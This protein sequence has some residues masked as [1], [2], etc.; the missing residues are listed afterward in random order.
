MDCRGG[1]LL[2]CGR[3]DRV[4]E[5]PDSLYE[6]VHAGQRADSGVLPAGDVDRAGGGAVRLDSADAL[7]TA[8]PNAGSLWDSQCPADARGCNPSRA[9][10]SLGRGSERLLLVDHVSDD[11][12]SGTERA[13]AEYKAWRLV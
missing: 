5:Q 7:H 8:K 11:F 12:C 9:D 6:A 3:T 2:Q 13:G 4:V 10:R 1:E